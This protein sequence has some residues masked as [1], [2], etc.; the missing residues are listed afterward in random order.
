MLLIEN[1]STD[2]AYNHA[3][4]EYLLKNLQEDVFMVWQNVPTI[5]IGRNQDA[6]C[7]YDADYVREKG[8]R[9]VRRLS[10]GGTIY[11]DLENL[12]YTL[13]APFRGEGEGKNPFLKFAAPVV[14]AL[15]RLGIDAEFTGRN[16]ITVEG[17]KVSGNAQF[18]YGSRVLHHGTLLFDVDRETISRALRPNPVKF[19]NKQV[20][21]VASRIGTLAE[22]VRMD[23]REFMETLKRHFMEHYSIRETYALREEELREVMRIKRERFDSPSWNLGVRHRFT[24]TYHVRHPFG[25]IGY[26]LEVDAGVIRHAEILGDFF[27]DRDVL[28]LAK[29]LEGSALEHAALARELDGVRVDDYIR[30]MENGAFI[31][32]VLSARAADAA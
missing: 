21:S 9:V 18:R 28:E 13:I 25:L 24:H 11:C 16:D 19:V 5:L 8:I 15:K 20:Q 26:R 6:L 10:G 29:R 2:P 3:L 31:E 30:G 22:Y 7:E 27:G 23:V 1:P 32:D 4:E 12:Q 14:E 17:K